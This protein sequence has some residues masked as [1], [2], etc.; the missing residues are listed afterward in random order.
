MDEGRLRVEAEVHLQLGQPGMAIGLYR[1]FLRQAG[2]GRAA[3]WF[4]L[5]WCLK[6]SADYA[7]AL[8][9]YSVALTR[10]VE[11]PEEAHLNRAVI[12]AD[13][14]NQDAQADTELRAALACRPGWPPALLNRGNLMEEAGDRAQALSCYDQLL[15]DGSEADAS[16]RSEAL[17]RWAHL[18]VP[19]AGHEAVV[20][21]LRTQLARPGGPGEASAA[22]NLHF[23]LGRVLDQAGRFGEAMH[24][25][26]QANRLAAA[27][28][29]PYVAARAAAAVEALMEASLAPPPGPTLARP[30]HFGSPA[31]LFICGQYRSG[32]TLLE[33]VLSSHSQVAMGGELDI[34]PR[35]TSRELAPFPGALARLGVAQA[36]ALAAAY[37]AEQRLRVAH[38][39][40]TRY[41]TDKRPDN[42]L[43]I[44]VIK[45]VFPG[46]RL[47]HTAR[48]PLDTAV[49]IYSQHL[50]QGRLPY[51]SD[52]FA[53]GHQLGLQQRVVQT[54][55]QRWGAD[56]HEF[57]YD[58]FV[59]APRVTLEPLLA[60]LG[61]PWEDALLNF[62]RREGAVRTAS[63]WQVR[64][65][66]YQASSG[67]WKHYEA[68]LGPVIEG[69]RAAGAT[70]PA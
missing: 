16:Q 18:L 47:V 1:R 4:N 64:Q 51:A 7:A 60:F 69:M 17:A 6:A 32:S 59:R 49:S 3:D 38:S 33:Q 52:L 5:G 20:Q 15:D 57:D 65:P 55:R 12:L 25:W 67:R 58:M 19:G 35:W 29:P 8:H 46:V 36:Q 27:L 40:S 41:I 53:I 24:A 48:H 54:W 43:L 14:L 70:L 23:A 21:R 9:A 13:F 56:I 61:L 22:A 2:D 66:L 37:L 50:A 26:H 10:G 30:A 68:F 39:P 31:P 42:H 62:H 63:Y 34:V 11:R 28:G 44:G 45:R